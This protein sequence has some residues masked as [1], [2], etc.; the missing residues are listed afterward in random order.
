MTMP[1][2]SRNVASFPGIGSDS[3][4]T[5]APNGSGLSA[6]GRAA[7]AGSCRESR[8]SLFIRLS[9]GNASLSI[10]CWFFLEWMFLLASLP[11]L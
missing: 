11:R 10:D 5:E 3:A 4:A 8:E 2:A 1:T 7:L 6:S 9:L